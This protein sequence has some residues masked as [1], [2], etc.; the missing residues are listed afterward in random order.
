[1]STFHPSDHDKPG[2][3]LDSTPQ[4]PSQEELSE[5][6]AGGGGLRCHAEGLQSNRPDTALDGR[7]VYLFNNH[8]CNF[9]KQN[10]AFLLETQKSD[11]DDAEDDSSDVLPAEDGH[12]SQSENGNSLKVTHLTEGGERDDGE[13]DLLSESKAIVSGNRE[14]T[15]SENPNDPVILKPE[16]T[17]EES[18]RELF[19]SLG[20]LLPCGDIPNLSRYKILDSSVQCIQSLLWRRQGMKRTS[21]ENVS[22]LNEL[23]TRKAKDS[24]ETTLNDTKGRRLKTVQVKDKNK[25]K[26]ANRKY[27]NENKPKAKSKK[28][29]V[30][31]T[32]V[33][34][35]SKIN[36]TSRKVGITF[37]NE[38]NSVVGITFVNENNSVSQ[39]D[40][41]NKKSIA[42]FFED[43]QKQ[44]LK[45]SKKAE[46]S[47]KGVGSKTRSPRN[48]K[49]SKKETKK[50][51]RKAFM[52]Y[53]RVWRSR[54][55]KEMPGCTRAQ[56][57]SLLK[58]RWQGL[59][60]KTMK[61]YQKKWEEE[62]QETTLVIEKS[63]KNEGKEGT[64]QSK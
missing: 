7:K 39:I 44:V 2:F 59:S 34:P 40:D 64:T 1:M 46:A 19:N 49:L 43:K 21:L 55:K 28:V 41:S 9:S 11:I 42:L 5:V 54:L 15:E 25:T 12:S 18:I 50:L 3:T 23:K 22:N 52:M 63:K 14:T 58:C 62:S 20:K 8:I 32:K 16:K 45:S 30:V 56:I 27:K 37:V 31:E 57:T 35:L 10:F 29:S 6:V 60:R 26:Q 53:A 24:C 36:E 61:R 17:R 38:C 13:D 33:N 51:E 48:T 4:Q 47:K